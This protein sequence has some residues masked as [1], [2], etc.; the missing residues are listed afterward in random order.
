MHRE[1]V[2]ASPGFVMGRSNG[3]DCVTPLVDRRLQCLSTLQLRV[4]PDCNPVTTVVVSGPV[5]GVVSCVYPEA[6]TLDLS[7]VRRE[8]GDPPVGLLVAVPPRNL[9]DDRIDSLEVC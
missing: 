2:Q 4:E 3:N 9:S 1:R 6:E 5:V 7:V 8:V